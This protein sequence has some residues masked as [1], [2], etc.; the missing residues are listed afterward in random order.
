MYVDAFLCCVP[1]TRW[2]LFIMIFQFQLFIQSFFVLF[3]ESLSALKT[4]YCSIPNKKVPLSTNSVTKTNRSRTKK[5]TSV[6]NICPYI[7][8]YMLHLQC[9]LL[10]RQKGSQRLKPS[11]HCHSLAIQ[12]L[13]QIEMLCNVFMLQKQISAIIFLHYIFL[14]RFNMLMLL[15]SSGHLFSTHT[16]MHVSLQY[17]H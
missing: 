8:R 5:V 2:S 11:M 7:A 1:I 3:Q 13:V 10:P 12:K 14:F 6:V 15:I 17:A 4:T 16:Y 9:Q